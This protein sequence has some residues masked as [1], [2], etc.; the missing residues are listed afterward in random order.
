[1]DQNLIRRLDK[2]IDVMESMS[3]MSAPKRF[4]IIG[5]SERIGSDYNL[6]EV[7]GFVDVVT[8]ARKN[9]EA[10]N[11]KM[12]SFMSGVSRNNT[13]LQALSHKIKETKKSTE[14][15]NKSIENQSE[16]Y[17]KSAVAMSKFVE[18]AGV[19]SKK[20]FELSQSLDK[21]EE[22][23]KK[24]QQKIESRSKS[25]EKLSK[26]TKDILGSEIKI[27]EDFKNLDDSFKTV[28]SAIA[29][30]TAELESKSKSGATQE[31][32]K[33]EKQLED[34]NEA[35]GSLEA[36]KDIKQSTVEL[37]KSIN[38]IDLSQVKDSD[39]EEVL[40]EL[41]KDARSQNANLIKKL[42]SVQDRLAGAQKGAQITTTGELRKLSGQMRANN[43]ALSQ[44]G[45][46]LI[47][48]SAE[49]G[50]REVSMV[51]T[52][53]ARVGGQ[54]LSQIPAA[55]M[56]MSESDLMRVQDE[57]RFLMRR[58]ALA[59]G[60]E[61]GGAAFVAS[62]EF[63]EI[64]NLGKILGLVGVEAAETMMDV[65]ESL[66]VLGLDSTKE[67]LEATTQFIKDSHI[68]F[69]LTQDQ[70]IKS[71]S[72]M[73][74]GGLLALRVR[75]ETDEEIREAMQDEVAFR[76][77]LARALNQSIEIQE[78]HNRQHAAELM[79]DPVELFRRSIFESIAAQQIGLSQ[80]DVDLVQ[81]FRMGEDMSSEERQRAIELRNLI[82]T[83]TADERLSAQLGGDFGTM[84]VMDRF[85]RGA[86]IDVDEA[87][88]ELQM[89]R[90][91]DEAAA[92]TQRP[93]RELH[94]FAE[95]VMRATEMLRGFSASSGAGL[96]GGALSVGADLAMIRMALGRSR[97]G[98][99]IDRGAGR[100]AGAV[101]GAVRGGAGMIGRGYGATRSF[102]T[103]TGGRM[104][105]R[106]AAPVAAATMVGGA[107]MDVRRT[108]QAL[109]AGEISDLEARQERVKTGLGVGGRLAGMAA[110][111]KVGAMGGAAVGSVG[112]PLALAT[113]L[114]G[115]IGGAIVGGVAA[116][117]I[118]ETAANRMEDSYW[119][120]HIDKGATGEIISSTPQ[121]RQGSKTTRSQFRANISEHEL[122]QENPELYRRY[123]DY[124]ADRKSEI[125]EDEIT[126]RME[127][128][129][130]DASPIRKRMEQSAAR[131]TADRES[132]IETIKFFKDELNQTLG[133][134]TVVYHEVTDIDGDWRDIASEDATGPTPKGI[135]RPDSPEVA[136][137]RADFVSGVVMRDV[138]GET[139][140]AQ[141]TDEDRRRLEEISRTQRGHLEAMMQ[142][143][144][145]D[146]EGNAEDIAV[147]RQHRLQL[148]QESRDIIDSY[149][150][151]EIEE[152]NRHQE[153]LTEMYG[154]MKD[155][156]QDRD[157][158][159]VG[160]FGRNILR[161]KEDPETQLRLD[162]NIDNLVNMFVDMDD[163]ELVH[164]FSEV[165]QIEALIK[166]LQADDEKEEE[167]KEL[168][169]RLEGIMNRVGDN[170][171]RSADAEEKQLS[172]QDALISMA[173]ESYWRDRL[174]SV[175]GTV[176]EL[177]DQFSAPA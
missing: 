31:T 4:P 8:K 92:E 111:A 133:E 82:R 75:G 15:L 7:E 3:G 11:K 128:L 104:L 68:Q 164:A 33:L 158:L 45:R 91:A 89:L 129:P 169:E 48:G 65:A 124:Q 94:A 98:R 165:K 143:R 101:S 80:E 152:Q 163:L 27:R 84:A 37:R 95:A 102:V 73:T 140:E 20:V 13:L 151:D 105:M 83:G 38:D 43:A 16:S 141:A 25:E 57:R 18:G 122:F 123:K 109:E 21:V 35:L 113:G 41:K 161:R 160:W 28:K 81:R 50:R 46:V 159:D 125:Y 93:A 56:G 116:D 167:T 176:K 131:R 107:A 51:Q 88:R 63:R 153:R 78:R 49:M 32:S 44:L 117:R 103:G 39:V 58:M 69:G 59:S 127:R 17:K 130:E 146:P 99:A 135:G 9:L 53:Q 29:K 114:V 55:M 121:I 61:G 72:E 23:A 87:T 171:E 66:R 47:A 132:Q 100:V 96:L 126:R 90:G 19:N 144:R 54:F 40:Q 71:F 162:D 139:L 6:N 12:D 118:A 60:E 10:E 177:N 154:L 120:E 64:Q 136:R 106:G 157:E 138:G 1:M 86:G 76:M 110:G 36:L 156:E 115:A 173:S 22:S 149:F 170:T 148:L 74:E 174:G 77:R 175:D 30:T 52:R 112:G 62:G 155:I 150:T 70:M 108:N 34:L 5:N 137:R 26:V 14:E 168:L 97:L 172:K 142:M 42:G 147:L 119:R 67:V 2:L 79:G 145:E 166:T 85:M 134:G 24:L